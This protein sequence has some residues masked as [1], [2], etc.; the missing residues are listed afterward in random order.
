MSIYAE[1]S[2]PFPGTT[3]HAFQHIAARDEAKRLE[4]R[5]ADAREHV[6]LHRR[7]ALSNAWTALPRVG[8][9]HLDAMADSLDRRTGSRRHG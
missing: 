1:L 7:A 9:S 5:D 2:F 3:P 4:R 6:A 8:A